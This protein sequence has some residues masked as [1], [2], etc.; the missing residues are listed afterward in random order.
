VFQQCLN[1]LVNF[2]RSQ[3]PKT[4][5]MV[6]DPL[7]YLICGAGHAAAMA[8]VQLASSSGLAVVHTGLVGGRRF[9]VCS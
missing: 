3:V 8:T 5:N 1:D 7:R 6:Y 2:A 9:D 4:I